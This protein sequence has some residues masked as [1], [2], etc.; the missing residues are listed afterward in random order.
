VQAFLDA[1]G[2][3]FA[4]FA[5]PGFWLAVIIGTLF[6]V[7]VGA[8]P[9]LGT[10]LAYALI[11]PFTYS[12]DVTTTIALL[13]SVA[14]GVQYGN[15]IP[16]ILVGV[17]G[18]P[19]A[20]LSV[21]DGFAMH[22][23]GKTSLALGIAFVSALSG[24]FVSILFFAAAVIPLAAV[25]FHFLNPELFALYLFGIFAI[26]SLTGRNVLKGLMAA[27]IGLLIAVVGLDPVNYQPRFT[28]DQWFLNTGLSASAAIIG[29]LAVSELFRQSRQAFQWGGTDAATPKIRFPKMREFKETLVPMAGGTVV[30]TLVGAIPGAGGTPAAL[31]SYQQAQMLSKKPSLFGK[32]SPEGLA[33]NEAA[34]NASSSGELI[35]T[36]GLGIPASGSTTLLLAALNLNGFVPGPG[37]VTEFPELFAA[38]VGGLMGSTLFLVLTGWPMARV[39]LKVLTVNRTLVIVGAL[40]T[41]V[42]GVYSLNYRIEDVVV[43]FAC[44]AIGYFM[45]RYGYSTAAAALAVILAAGLEASLRR[46]LSLFDDDVVAFVSRPITAGIL[47]LACVFLA[48]GVRR[49]ITT[50]RAEAAEAA[51]LAAATTSSPAKAE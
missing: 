28:F 38:V 11:L 45:L 8:L 26:V 32:G 13:M 41:V 12:L 23:Q 34:Q 25:A 29:F 51:A 31:I 48:V 5:E 1:L 22:K 2:G 24:Q 7:V 4:L 47:V 36:L 17:P 37:L 39:M 50:G 21:L 9:G 27:C 14:V 3:G 6:G 15:S 46:G 18:S 49:T 43:C 42:M 40:L 30:G 19:A 44:G 10:T 16:A 35:P 33:A 20:V